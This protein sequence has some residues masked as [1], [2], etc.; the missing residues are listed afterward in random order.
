MAGAV[1]RL[2]FCAKNPPL[3]Q[4]AKRYLQPFS[5]NLQKNLQKILSS[6]KPIYLCITQTV[7]PFVYM[8]KD[9]ATEELIKQ[10]AKT[11]FTKKGLDGARMQDIADEAKVNKGLLN[12]YFRSKEKLFNIIFDEAFIALF[13]N[14]AKILE[15]DIPLQEKI[16]AIIKSESE[17][18]IANP[19]LPLFV[20]NEVG[21]NQHIIQDK[22]NKSPVK[23]ILK[24][25]SKQVQAEVKKGTIRSVNGK[26]L[27]VNI[28]SLL[29][30]PF[31]AKNL[32]SSLFEMEEQAFESFMKQR[33]QEVIQFILAALS[34]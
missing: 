28:I 14:T 15:T 31:I 19:F 34:R 29:M 11:I 8:Q 32:F 24:L 20:L 26:D 5:D 6:R 3:R 27:F 9:S 30:F 33:Q 16:S 17:T 22:I 1:L 21:R 13:S 2:N 23:S 12:Y 7:K 10:A 4:A 18:I 25:F